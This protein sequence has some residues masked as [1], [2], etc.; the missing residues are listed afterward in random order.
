MTLD[1]AMRKVGGKGPWTSW[2]PPPRPPESME[3]LCLLQR[4]GCPSQIR[5]PLYLAQP[6]DTYFVSYASSLKAGRD[7]FIPGG[8][9][10]A[11]MMEMSPN[12]KDY[13]IF[14]PC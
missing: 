7:L 13:N 10:D 8:G 5:G 6:P 3:H 12:I 14:L 9:A 4:E 2:D 1:S 11:A